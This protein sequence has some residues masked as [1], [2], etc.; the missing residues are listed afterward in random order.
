MLQ[1][2]KKLGL[3]FAMTAVDPLDVTPTEFF[4]GKHWFMPFHQEPR[5]LIPPERLLP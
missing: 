2:N 4:T 3:Y 1:D 5:S